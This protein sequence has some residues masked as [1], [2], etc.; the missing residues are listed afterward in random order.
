MTTDFTKGDS[1]LSNSRKVADV[2]EGNRLFSRS[3]A[4]TEVESDHHTLAGKNFSF[5]TMPGTHYD[6]VGVL[7]QNAL[8]R[9]CD[10]V[11]QQATPL[12]SDRSMESRELASAIAVDMEARLSMAAKRKKHN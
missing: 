4:D 9:N 3:D 11:W 2:G 7:L 12:M 5:R 1:G 8:H 6:D 10:T